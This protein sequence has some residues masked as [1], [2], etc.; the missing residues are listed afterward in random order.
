M[1]PLFAGAE[2]YA[3][4]LKS[5]QEFTIPNEECAA[6]FPTIVVDDIALCASA[7][8]TASFCEV[9]GPNISSNR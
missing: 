7:G 8:E 2:D 3:G 9:K 4:F 6:I 5:I 1:N